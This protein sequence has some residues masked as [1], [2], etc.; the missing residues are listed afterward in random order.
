LVVS[1][2]AN[3]AKNKN[4]AIANRSRVSCVHNTSKLSRPIVTT[5]PWSRGQMSLKVIGNGII[6][7]RSYMTWVIWLWILWWPWN[8]G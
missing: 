4:L 8:V 6:F 1:F 3:I 2:Y 5:W 7:D